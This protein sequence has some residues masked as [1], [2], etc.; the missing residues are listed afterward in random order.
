[1]VADLGQLVANILFPSAFHA[2]FLV[3]DAE[4]EAQG[5]PGLFF[6]PVW[7][8]YLSIYQRIRSYRSFSRMN[9][10]PS[11]GPGSQKNIHRPTT[12]GLRFV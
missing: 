12:N 2:G 7:P 3:L 11:V 6:N 10:P 1:M 5:S 4:S 8:T 9:I